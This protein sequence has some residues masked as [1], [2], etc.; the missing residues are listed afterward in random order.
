VLA[1]VM[2]GLFMVVMDFNIVTVALPAMMHAFH[3]SEE[4]IKLV[5]ES[6]ALSYAI[7]TLTGSWIRERIGIKNTFVGGLLLFTFSS[8]MCGLSWS[9]PSMIFFR[10]I[11]AVGGGIMMPTG[12]TMMS[13][14]FPPN[15]RGKAFGIFGTVIVFAPSIGPTLG[16]YL[17]D[18]WHWSYVFFINIPVGAAVF[19]LASRVMRDTRPLQPSRF[20]LAGFLSLAGSLAAL[21]I[22]LNIVRDRGWT[23]PFIVGLFTAAIAAFLIFLSAASRAAHPIIELRLFRIFHFSILSVLNFLRSFTLFARIVLVPLLFQNVLGLS[24]FHT[25]LLVM[26]NA[27][28]AGVTMPAIGPFIDRFGPR[29]FIVWGFIIQAAG[30]F[31]FYNIGLATPVWYIVASMIIFGIGSGMLGTPVTSASM[32]VVPKRYIGQVSIILTVVM[33]VGQAF[34]VAVF[35]TMAVMR[36]AAYA[37]GAPISQLARLAGYQ[38]AFIAMGVLSLISLIPALGTFGIPPAHEHNTPIHLPTPME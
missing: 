29:W 4:H 26:P 18:Y 1:T 30:S 14:S 22:A 19:F 37:H 2:C 28:A 12:F 6:Y 32:N 38:E 13:E 8:L 17:V 23:D 7:F 34:G 36:A 31:M 33:Q 11:K 24:A 15:E 16:G 20:D 25:G 35:G 9:L 21:L 5:V 10:I 27:I 3:T